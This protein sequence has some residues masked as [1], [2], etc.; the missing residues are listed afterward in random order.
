MER[1]SFIHFKNYQTS[2]GRK[3][4]ER[5][6]AKLHYV[7]KN[8]KRVKY[9]YYCITL[10]SEISREIRE[11]DVPYLNIRQDNF[12]GDIDFLF[13]KENNPDAI[14]ISFGSG[15]SKCISIYCKGFVEKIMELLG[16]SEDEAEDYPLNIGEN[17][18]RI[19]DVVCLQVN[20]FN[21]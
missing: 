10:N 1:F 15:N 11:K 7:S 9:P 4:I 20:K 19:A 6:T 5:C 21:V 12:T 17:R 2:G 18:S 14:K 8:C 16:I 13:T 3:P